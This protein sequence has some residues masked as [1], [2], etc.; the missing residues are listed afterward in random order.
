MS[1]IEGR[2]IKTLQDLI[3]YGHAALQAARVRSPGIEADAI[4]FPNPLDMR[5]TE[6]PL[7]GGTFIYDILASSWFRK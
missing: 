3:D 7:S 2:T 4:L 5:L 6:M 1:V